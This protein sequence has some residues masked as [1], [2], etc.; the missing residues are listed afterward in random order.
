[1]ISPWRVPTSTKA[2]MSDQ[3]A[4]DTNAVQTPR[5]DPPSAEALQ[6][7]A[8]AIE[9]I[10]MVATDPMEDHVLAQLLELPV[11]T[12]RALCGDLAESYEREERGFQ[13][14]EVGGGW[15]FQ[16]HP[17][18]APYVE[19][20]VLEG[21]SAR[22]SSAALETLAIVAYKQPISRGQVS[23]IRGVNVDG[24]LRT[25]SQRGY[26]EEIGRDLGP[27]QATLFGTTR[28][29]L[30]RLGLASIDALPPLGDFVP[31]AEVVEA[32]E[33]TLRASPL[34]DV[35]IVQ[36]EVEAHA[37]VDLGGQ[38][39]GAPA[40]GG[41]ID[42]AQIDRAHVDRGANADID[43]TDEPDDSSLDLTDENDGSPVDLIDL[44]EE[45][46]TTF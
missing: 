32:L 22:L 33:Q 36:P 10:V 29:F 3:A 7:A 43:L 27:G 6:E 44:D 21:Q 26:V 25:L 9:A 18:Q 16:T 37:D 1:M 13:L 40:Y 34:D 45:P 2:D 38:T 24:V 12:V 41:Q 4:E 5:A 35:P 11:A 30:E 14:A 46:T 17:D 28:E 8:R 20:Y 23:A 31:S 15:R 39:D 19:R 42:R